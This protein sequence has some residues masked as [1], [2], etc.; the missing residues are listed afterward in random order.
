MNE[1][2]TR[3]GEFSYVTVA[4]LSFLLGILA[5]SIGD[6]IK[7]RRERT[8]L[9]DL[10]I[11]DI[12]R[13]WPN[14]DSVRVAPVG[15]MLSRACFYF[16]GVDG[17]FLRGNPEYLF[18]VYNLKFFETEGIKLAQLLPT[19][20]RKELWAAYSLLRDAEAVRVVLKD[21]DSADPDYES[22]QKLLLE[23]ASRLLSQLMV[24]EDV[25]WRERTWWAKM[26]RKSTELRSVQVPAPE[27]AWLNPTA[28]VDG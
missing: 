20:P 27:R 12:R 14:V 23:L 28:R 2:L 26:V 18:E 15:P 9:I 19:K 24:V 6:N 8:R 5:S 10:F 7:R 22:Y 25:L 1:F 13:N 17:L 16:K 3:S 11:Q 21:L 4:A